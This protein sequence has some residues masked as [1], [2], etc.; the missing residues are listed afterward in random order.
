MTILEKDFE[1]RKHELNKCELSCEW[2]TRRLVGAPRCPGGER[3]SHGK[4]LPMMSFSSGRV[5]GDLEVSG[6]Y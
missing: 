6:N 3:V 2:T 5:H 4:N 1:S